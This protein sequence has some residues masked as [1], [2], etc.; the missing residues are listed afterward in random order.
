MYVRSFRK[1]A[2]VAELAANL[3]IAL[4]RMQNVTLVRALQAWRRAP[5]VPTPGKAAASHMLNQQLSKVFEKLRAASDNMATLKHAASHLA[6]RGL[7]T[8]WRSWEAFMED[9]A[10]MSQALIVLFKAQLKRAIN[11]WAFW[12][13]ARADANA[14]VRGVFEGLRSGKRAA[15]NSW[16]ELIDTRDRMRHALAHITGR[17]LVKAIGSWEKF[18]VD[19]RR[20]RK[21]LASL[22]HRASYAAMA[23]WKSIA[24]QRHEK[25]DRLRATLSAFRA[26]PQKKAINTW[27]GFVQE[28]QDMRKALGRLILHGQAK[29]ISSWKTLVAKGHAQRE[30]MRAALF[31][32][33]S[34]LCAGFNS[35]REYTLELQLARKALSSLF[36]NS[37]RKVFNKWSEYTDQKS[38]LHDAKRYAIQNLLAVG[39]RKALN[40][41]LAL[42]ARLEPLRHAAAHIIY[43]A[44]AKALTT[45]VEYAIE[46]E[47][48]MGIINSLI[49]SSAKRALR[50]WARSASDRDEKMR[51]MRGMLHTLAGGHR[52]LKAINSWKELMRR[53]A[54]TRETMKAALMFDERKAFNTWL[55]NSTDDA[56][57]KL[58][59]R[60]WKNCMRGGTFRRWRKQSVNVK[61]LRRS[62]SHF[63]NLGISRSW[64]SWLEI[65]A[66]MHL[67][68]RAF[69]SFRLVEVMRCMNTWL[70][71]VEARKGR[72]RTLLSGV[73]SF[74]NLEVR[75]VWNSWRSALATLGP[76]RRAIAHWGDATRTRVFFMLRRDAERRHHLRQKLFRL[77]NFNLTKGFNTWVLR[78]KQRLRAGRF[79]RAFLHLRE[80]RGF[81]SWIAHWRGKRRLLALVHSW[82]GGVRRGFNKWKANTR[83]R[84]G[85]LLGSPVG[86]RC[87]RAMTWREVC[88][89]LNRIGIPVSRSP[90][91]LLMSLKSGKPYAELVRR[92]SPAFHVRHKM[93]KIMNT[94]HLFQAIQVFFETNTVVRTLGYQR[95]AV[96]ALADDAPGQG[97]AIE[98]LE[99]LASFREVMEEAYELEV[100][101]R[102]VVYSPGL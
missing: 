55:G 1:L 10:L 102:G 79:G 9:M 34:G 52:T 53:A 5:L 98:H 24:A 45:W 51:I 68:L 76:L 11:T 65:R 50:R 47:R 25:L 81:N 48:M 49:Y 96:R 28:R 97:G 30:R 36:A 18:V 3:K 101:R 85:E 92:L 59:R 62:M 33:S 83:R 89:W 21:A 99:L 80:R 61:L 84:A 23:Q 91:T 4:Y 8:A 19:Q 75:R 2:A 70:L 57:A 37:T 40:S 42:L 13:D 86:L 35:W 94:L 95:I 14:K 43:A 46:C 17:G 71:L 6:N 20:M 58:A 26:R 15:F 54:Q 77:A 32:L 82:R 22:I 88:V 39:L 87:V 56:F 31:A 60:H 63:V 66:Q 38:A 7:A 74:L 73:S 16:R 29:A 100:A 78:M 12:A 90:P 64:R 44:A 67:M 41:W 93:D 69:N 27:R 72:M